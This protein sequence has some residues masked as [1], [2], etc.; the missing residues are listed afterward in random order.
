MLK[1]Y[2]NQYVLCLSDALI[3]Q[4]ERIKQKKRRR[5]DPSAL[6]WKP[7]HF[8]KE[9]L[10]FGESDLADR[11]AAW[12]IV[13]SFASRLLTGGGELACEHQ[14]DWWTCRSARE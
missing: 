5:I 8:S 6:K 11:T 9:Q 4:N 7:P 2:K 14:G 3:E 13:F 1:F 12:L 10:R